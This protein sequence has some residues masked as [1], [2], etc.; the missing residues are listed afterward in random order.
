MRSS[1]ERNRGL[2]VLKSRGMAHSNQIREFLLSSEGV[3]LVPVYMGPDGVLTGSARAAAEAVETGIR[4]GAEQ[5][6]SQLSEAMELR[7]KAVETHVTS[8]WADFEAEESRAARQLTASKK[9]K[10]DL[11]AARLEQG[12]QRTVKPEDEP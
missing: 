4:L 3:S 2:Y 11:R 6:S 12:R 7:R 9:G 10:E 8:M 1:G 5:E